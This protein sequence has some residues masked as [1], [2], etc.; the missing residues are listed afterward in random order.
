V[1][2]ET[3]VRPEIAD[4]ILARLAEN[5]FEHYAVFAYVVNARIA[6]SEKYV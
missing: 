1:R 6:R 3:V 2:I 4:A 5:Y